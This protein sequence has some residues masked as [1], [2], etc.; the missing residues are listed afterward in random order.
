[1]V[2]TNSSRK[3][4]SNVRTTN[5][6]L[7]TVHF[8][9]ICSSLIQQPLRKVL[10]PLLQKTNNDYCE[11]NSSKIRLPN[12]PETF[13]LP[14]AKMKQFSSKK[15]WTPFVIQLIILCFLLNLP[16]LLFACSLLQLSVY[17]KQYRLQV[18]LFF[19]TNRQT[20]LYLPRNEIVQL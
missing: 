13:M 14:F 5:I 7:Q 20:S 4:F 1:M 18:I 11:L 12:E 6:R 10:R 16:T 8:L 17:V 15:F 19:L 3:Y 9:C 2:C